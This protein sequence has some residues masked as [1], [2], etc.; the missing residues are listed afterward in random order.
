RAQ[1]EEAQRDLVEGIIADLVVARDAVVGQAEALASQS[2]EK[3]DAVRG[4][5]DSMRVEIQQAKEKMNLVESVAS[6]AK[7]VETAKNAVAILRGKI[8]ELEASATIPVAA[9]LRSPSWLK[10]CDTIRGNI[11]LGGIHATHW[12]SSLLPGT[13]DYGAPLEH[14]IRCSI[15]TNRWL[16]SDDLPRQ[17]RIDDQSRPKEQRRPSSPDPASPIRRR[18]RLHRTG[19]SS[20]IFNSSG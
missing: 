15:I 19:S 4:E 17:Q 9:R 11:V 16:P 10:Y 13:P 2:F 5:L 1:R 20:D 8:L 3:A 6:D 12:R 18:H 7:V 14:L